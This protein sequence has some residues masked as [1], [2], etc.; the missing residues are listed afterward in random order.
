MSF[1]I[2]CGKQIPDNMRF[3]KYCGTEVNTTPQPAPVAAY[4]GSGEEETV[5]MGARPAQRVVYQEPPNDDAYP[6]VAVFDEPKK[7]RHTARWVVLVI[8]LL[9]L[10]GAAFFLLY[11]ENYKEVLS[12]IG[13]WQEQEPATIAAWTEPSTTVAPK[14]ADTLDLPLE[15]D[16]PEEETLPPRTLPPMGETLPDGSGPISISPTLYM[17]VFDEDHNLHIRKGPSTDYE[18]LGKIPRNGIV[19]ATQIWDD[20]AYVEYNGIKG[21]STM[22]YLQKMG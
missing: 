19:I 9:L 3:C 5:F 8:L 13:L 11:N 4:V 2:H 6:V 10:A 16:F 14:T 15:F 21:W 20:W 1:C 18:I 22:E 12:K 17:V 7:Q